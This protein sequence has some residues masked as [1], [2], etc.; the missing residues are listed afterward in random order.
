MALLLIRNG[1]EMRHRPFRFVLP[2]EAI[3]STSLAALL[4]D[5]RA[6]SLLEWTF[7]LTTDT[8]SPPVLFLQDAV[9][10][11]LRVTLELNQRLTLLEEPSGASLPGYFWSHE[12]WP[13]V[14]TIPPLPSIEELGGFK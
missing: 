2:A 6:R 1:S 12:N 9:A 11:L 8:S 14:K 3:T 4:E 10:T 5:L 13:V 7:D